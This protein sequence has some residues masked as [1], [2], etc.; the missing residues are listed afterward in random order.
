M[1]TDYGDKRFVEPGFVEPVTQDN[2]SLTV[3]LPSGELR[4]GQYSLIL[5]A[6]MSDGASQRISGSYRFNLQ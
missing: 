4:R 3:M 6:V 2:Q 5:F 1:E